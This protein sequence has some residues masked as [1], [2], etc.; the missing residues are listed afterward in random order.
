VQNNSQID[1]G[2]DQALSVAVTG[3]SAKNVLLLVDGNTMSNN[4]LASTAQI[5]MNGGGTLNATVGNNTMSNGN[6]GAARAL[7][8]EST[9]GI[10]RLALNDNTG[11][12]SGVEE[13]ILLDETGGD[14]R[15]EDL[16]TVDSRNGGPGAIEFQPN[17]AAF[18]DDPGPIPTPPNP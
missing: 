4:S 17:Q 10:V 16:A 8:M 9:S 7:S 3:G 1:G 5:D 2:D 13:E 11:I 6:A 15:I 14:F 12:N 18:T